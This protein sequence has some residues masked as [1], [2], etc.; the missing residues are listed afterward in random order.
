[1]HGET[2]VPDLVPVLSRGKHRN[3]R[4][5]ACFMELASFLA[6]E[7][8]SD[9]PD[10]TH[11]LLASLARLVNDFTTDANRSRLAGLIPSVIGV[12]SDDPHLDVRIALRC[13]TTALP[14][15]SAERQRVMA[16]SVLA[17]QQAMVA[18]DG[19]TD[20]ELMARSRRAMVQV[21]HAARWAQ[22]FARAVRTS[23]RQFRRR[24]APQ[25][26]HYAVEG[27]AQ[28]CV[29]DPDRILHDLL[30]ATVEDCRAWI[31]PSTAPTVDARSWAAACELAGLSLPR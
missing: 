8:W 19:E 30:K 21:P 11:P 29:E 18:L 20:E 4:K 16:V 13:A 14:V 26:V 24:A 28:A 10:C 15:V 12:T 9:H 17:A 25:A 5:G 23:P 7:R 3:P 2:H 22:Q 1:M 27:I 6:G 31:L